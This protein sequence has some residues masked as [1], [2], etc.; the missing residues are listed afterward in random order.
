MNRL[1]QDLDE[2]AGLDIVL[3]R[4]TRPDNDEAHGRAATVR[5]NRMT[6]FIARVVTGLAPRGW[7]NGIA[8]PLRPIR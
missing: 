5:S 6:D 7:F 4:E 2:L 3:S 8:R 1:M